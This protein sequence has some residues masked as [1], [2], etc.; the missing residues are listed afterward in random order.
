MPCVFFNQTDSKDT[1]AIG[2]DSF[3]NTR[4]TIFVPGSVEL[5][6]GESGIKEVMAVT[7]LLHFSGKGE[8]CQVALR[9]HYVSLRSGSFNAVFM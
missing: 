2:Y 5:D 7:S 8:I 9:Y 3:S 1:F 4:D 6:I